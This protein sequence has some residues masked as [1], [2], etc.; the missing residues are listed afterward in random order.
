MPD[1]KLNT[2]HS[3]RDYT[4]RSLREFPSAEFSSSEGR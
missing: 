2:K 1:S 3:Q 4:G